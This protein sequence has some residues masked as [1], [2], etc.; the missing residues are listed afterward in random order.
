MGVKEQTCESSTDFDNRHHF[1]SNGKNNPHG[2]CL[3]YYFMCRFCEA[4][5]YIAIDPSEPFDQAV[6]WEREE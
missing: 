4:K 3:V 2:Q 1:V 6:Y 5:K